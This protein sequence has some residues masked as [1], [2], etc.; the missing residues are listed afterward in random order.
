MTFNPLLKERHV[1]PRWRSLKT[2]VNSGE[3]AMPRKATEAIARNPS[4]E[5]VRRLEAFR[6]RPDK[7]RVAGVI[8]TAIVEDLPEE[9]IRPARIVLL[10][11]SGATTLVREQ[12]SR[13]LRKVGDESELPDELERDRDDIH[14]SVALWR[15]ATRCYPHD[16]LPWV[17]LA[18]GYITICNNDPPFPPLPPP[19][20]LP[21][22]PP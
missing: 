10:R 12:A 22:P 1:I 6:L 13:L 15:S 21:P 5:L 11:D 14:S 8:E 9:A 4:E 20:H 17:E 3:L 2:T 19:F 7:F 16:P 18:L